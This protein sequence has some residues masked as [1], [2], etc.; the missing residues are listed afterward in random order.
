MNWAATEAP[1]TGLPVAASVTL[2]AIPPG[3][4]HGR[5]AERPGTGR[6]PRSADRDGRDA[7]PSALARAASGSVTANFPASSVTA[8][9]SI[10]SLA[11]TSCVMRP[12]AGWSRVRTPTRTPAT[13]RPCGSTTEPSTRCVRGTSLIAT[14]PALAR[15]GWNRRPA[16][17][18]RPRAP[19]GRH[20]GTLDSDVGRDGHAAI[21][22]RRE[23]A[24]RP[25]GRPDLDADLRHAGIPV[26]HHANPI[27]LGSRPAAAARRHRCPPRRSCSR[28]RHDR[29]RDRQSPG[30][31]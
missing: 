11:C 20:D 8:R 7:R 14:V 1:A 31:Q 10:G 29:G 26:I 13:G 15:S 22:A 21:V 25:A 19:R 12:F 5:R 27:R 9:P 23:S 18:R 30:H 6:R 3:R 16:P 24:E 4:M 2:P 17:T 28:C